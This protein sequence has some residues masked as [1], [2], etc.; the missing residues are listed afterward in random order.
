M[1]VEHPDACAEIIWCGQVGNLPNGQ[2]QRSLAS[3]RNPQGIP[4]L[5]SQSGCV[6]AGV[7]TDKRD[8][9]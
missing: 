3:G 8:W 4:L 2:K 6:L 7:V 9:T 5:E 1:S